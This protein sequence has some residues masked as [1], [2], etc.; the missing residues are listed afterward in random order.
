MAEPQRPSLAE[1]LPALAR[2]GAK[3][4][5]PFISQLEWSD[6]GAA[7]LTMVLHLHGKEVELMD[8]RKALAVSRDGVS[9]RAIVEGATRFG[10]IATGVRADV[11]QL[12]VLP[13]GT[14]LH[15]EFNHFVV[16]DRML[17]TGGAL[18]V[19]PAVG[20]REISLEELGRKYTGVAVQFV[21]NQSFS[22]HKSKDGAA[23]PYLR[24]LFAEGRLMWRVIAISLVLRLIS[25]VLPLM[26]GMIVDR[27]VPRSDYTMLLVTISAIAGLVLFHA[28]SALIR[29]N[30]LVHLRTVLDARM[31][32]GF[33]D[34]LVALPIGFFQKRS[35]GD[36]L[37]RVGSNSSM[38]EI[39]TSQ[40]LS[41]II[42]GAF[43]VLYAFVILWTNVTLGVVAILMALL[44]PAI[45]AA[46]RNRNM[47]LTTEDLQ[48]QAKSQS[49]LNEI[50]GGMETLKTA[51]AESAAVERWAGLYADVM[52]VSVRKGR[53]NAK[54]DALRGAVSQLA[55]MVVMGLG[56]HA[57]IKG[58]MTVGTML[59]MTT[60]AMSLFGPLSQLIESMLS[61]QM[62]TGYAARVQDVMKTPVEQQRESVAQPPRL[63]GDITLKGVSFGYSND[64]PAVLSNIDLQIPSGAK[65][66]L[67]GPSGSGK[68]TLLNLLAGTL[69]PTAGQISY[70]GTDLHAMDLKAVRQQIGIVPQAPFIFGASV[71]DNI[72]IT[73]PDASIERIRVAADMAALH[74]DITAMPLGY[75]TPIADG[76]STLSGG[77]RQRI[78]IARACLREPRILLF[79]EATSALDTATEARIV[80][81]V[82]RL[83]CT[84]ITVAHRLTTIQGHDLIVVMDQ[85]K[86]IEAGSHPQLLAKQ[87]LYSRLVAAA[88][89]PLSPA[90]AKDPNHAKAP[91]SAA[92]PDRVLDGRPSG[93]PGGRT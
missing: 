42:D 9:A 60:L 23:R 54:V 16:L 89:Q 80:A 36:L 76:G 35:A 20:V 49:Y 81:N 87:G 25:L 78:A 19:D 47:R 28:V 65:V 71:R 24:E 57:V 51:G 58:E 11:D 70:D 32:L 30:L 73:A 38:R 31:T 83:G 46:A 10:L 7:C 77:Q 13:R 59:A 92:A 27:V 88:T 93:G 26:T 40:T 37:L 15:W 33:L 3:R 72:A 53:L 48:A 44:P 4:E 14:I 86:V 45:Y 5:I 69:V 67:V 39:V 52:N 90:A 82:R 56:T 85:G 66:A 21:P 68:S 34:H 17:R 50:L 79:D 55:P 18:I 1:R 74:E 84:Q 22:K 8:V 43:V 12:A 29:S 61:L 91:A 64:R 62:L 75:D 63:R 41:A 2:V 6:C